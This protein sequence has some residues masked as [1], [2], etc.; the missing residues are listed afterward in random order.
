MVIHLKRS[1][2]PQ[3]LH[4]GDGQA[5]LG[6][7]WWHPVWRQCKDRKVSFQ[8]FSMGTEPVLMGIVQFLLWSWA[9]WG[10]TLWVGSGCHLAWSLKGSMVWWVGTPGMGHL[11]SLP[12]S[13]AHLLWDLGFVAFCTYA[14][15]CYQRSSPLWGGNSLLLGLVQSL[16]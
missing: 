15:P 7:P 13:A 10:L 2:F 14:T 12:I 4:H 8:V 5:E 11:S 9:R 3:R 16:V 1:T 6:F